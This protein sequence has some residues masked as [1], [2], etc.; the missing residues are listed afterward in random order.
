MSKKR[1]HK[2]K[3]KKHSEP[4]EQEKPSAQEEL[5]QVPPPPQRHLT[6]REIREIYNKA[7]AGRGVSEGFWNFHR[8]FTA[9]T[10]G[11]II[12]IL[13]ITIMIV[14]SGMKVSREIGSQAG[15]QVK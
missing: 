11:L 7:R 9:A 4:T 1:R 15:E 14:F 13:V 6:T 3:A 8:M 2:P 12:I 5:H 10:I